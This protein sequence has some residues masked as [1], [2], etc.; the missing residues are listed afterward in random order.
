MGSSYQNRLDRSVVLLTE[1]R[2]DAYGVELS[3]VIPTF[4]ERDNIN[5]L[6][7]AISAALP[8][9]R[10]EIIFVDDDSPD[11]TAD[12]I[13]QYAVR[14]FRIR[15]IRRYGRRGLSSA[16]IEGI[17]STTSPFVAVMDADLQHD[18]SLLPL[19]LA[20]LRKGDKDF[21]V[22]SRYVSGGSV[23]EWNSSR[24]VMSKFATWL[25]QQIIKMDIADPMSGF[26]MLRRDVFDASIRRLS[27]QGYKI[28][29]DIVASSPQK[30]RVIELP[31][32][33]RSRQH[34]ESK[35]DTLVLLEYLT[36]LMDK[37]FGRYIPVSFILFSAIGGLGVFVHMAILALALKI[38]A[39]EFLVAQAIATYAAM[40]FNFFLNNFLT[41][42]DKRLKGWRAV[43]GLLSFYVVCSVGAFANVGVANFLFNQHYQWWLSGIAGIAMGVVW[44]YAVSSVVTW[45]K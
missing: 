16:V 18:E 25:S 44:N 5:L 30:L 32:T 13:R 38:F 40:T 22:G 34:G 21:V 17:M 23:G 3:I 42:R 2:A 19:M 15:L 24:A 27:A 9:V 35:L 33:F 43:R 10:W 41:Y 4:N 14:D 31:Y 7:A 37:L 20:Q 29:L 11:G 39:V 36:L 45:K 12:V 1:T 28:L 8:D 6:I 26:F